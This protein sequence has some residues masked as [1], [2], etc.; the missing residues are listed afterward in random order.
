MARTCNMIKV[1]R[2]H[3]QRIRREEGEEERNKRKCIEE[4]ARD[5][6]TVL[7]LRERGTAEVDPRL[8]HDDESGNKIPPRTL[9]P[10]ETEL[11]DTPHR[12]DR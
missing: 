8:S 1:V 12:R 10:E 9:E 3:K 6:G 7:S 4:A 2:I 5:L 11:E